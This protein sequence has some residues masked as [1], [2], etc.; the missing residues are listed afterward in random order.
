MLG[1]SFSAQV[2]RYIKP[3]LSNDRQAVINAISALDQYEPRSLE[4]I[5]KKRRL[6]AKMPSRHKA[7]ASNAG[8]L[9]RLE[10]VTEAIFEN[11]Y[12]LKEMSEYA[13]LHHSI[14]PHELR[15]AA[16]TPNTRVIEILEH[17]VRDWSLE[18]VDNRKGLIDPVLKRLEAFLPMTSG[19][20]PEVLVPGSGL[21]RAAFEIAQ[22]G[23]KTT[24]VEYSMLMDIASKFFLQ[25]SRRSQHYT[26]HPYIHEF[27]HQVSKDCQLRGVEIPELN[28]IPHLPNLSLTYGDFTQ[29][30]Y[31]Y[32]AIVSLFF[33]DTAENIFSYLDNIYELTK[34]DGI[35]INFGPL[36]WGT[37]P[38]AELTMEELET[39]LIDSGQWVILD[40]FEGENSY[41]GDPKSLWTAQ[42]ALR[43]WVARKV[44]KDI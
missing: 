31:Q 15:F 16:S 11:S 33:I 29:V 8:Y 27:S 38:Q 35:W 21:A 1:N 12:V 42:Y 39:V 41:N 7:M 26:I 34:P 4:Q 32:D 25:N 22:K 44:L 30:S 28:A 3:P 19:S 36:K 18:T 13:K 40:K 23:Y 14:T 6:F 20:P 37:A 9:D 17:L 5:Q 2:L 10:A 43:G 24:A